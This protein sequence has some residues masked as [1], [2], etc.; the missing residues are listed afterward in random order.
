MSKKTTR[1]SE[2]A[3]RDGFSKASSN[4]PIRMRVGRF[5]AHAAEVRGA[6][7]YRVLHPRAA[8]GFCRSAS[9]RISRFHFICFVFVEST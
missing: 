1:I 6:P 9:A 2:C 8:T 3:L 5:S 7:P 4:L